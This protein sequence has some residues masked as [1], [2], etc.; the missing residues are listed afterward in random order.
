M[1][2]KGWDQLSP[3]YRDR[4]AKAGMTREDYEAGGS[5]SKARGHAKTPERPSSFDAKKF[6]QYANERQRLT[7]D[8]VKKKREHFYLRPKW[9][10]IEAKKT[11]DKLAPPLNRMRKALRWTLEEWLHAIRENPEVWAFLGYH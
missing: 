7:A 11:I 6:P 3:G 10:P 5:L 4:I 1:A 2:R 8:L 9:N